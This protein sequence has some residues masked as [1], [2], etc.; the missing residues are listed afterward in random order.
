MAAGAP[1]PQAWLWIYPVVAGLG[2][3]GAVLQLFV[4][5]AAPRTTSG[6]AADASLDA[7][8]RLDAGEDL[9]TMPPW[10]VQENKWRAARYGLD[11]I[12]ILDADS[13]ERL[14][15]DD[16]DDLLTR[17]E[18]VAR[19]LGCT[20]ELASVADIPRLGGSYQRQRRVAEEND[21]DLRAVVDALVGE[22]DV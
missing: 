3:G 4:P 20:D 15:T 10:H 6:A 18:P 11:A 19:S 16:L 14:V 21:G 2:A 13:N 12:I 7:W 22:L 8:R 5:P 9:P 1:Q 17:L